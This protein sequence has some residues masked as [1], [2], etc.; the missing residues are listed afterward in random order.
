MAYSG[1]M[2]LEG[3][4]MGIVV[5]TGSD[6]L[7]SKSSMLLGQDSEISSP[8]IRE[9]TGTVISSAILTL[10]FFIAAVY[11]CLRFGLR[12]LAMPVF[13][14]CFACFNLTKNI[15]SMI[16]G[17]FYFLLNSMANKEAIVKKMETLSTM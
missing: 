17:F 14:I 10:T 12:P 3:T 15:R 11:L 13:L 7:N 16:S 8:E 9:Y 5:A 6:T 1:A 4:G 2:I